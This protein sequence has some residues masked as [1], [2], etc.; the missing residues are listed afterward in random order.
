MARAAAIAGAG[1]AGDPPVDLR[2]RVGIE[3]EDAVAAAVAQRVGAGDDGLGLE[4]LGGPA[5]RHLGRHDALQVGLQAELV[6]GE[7]RAAVVAVQPQHA[8]VA[9]VAHAV[10]RLAADAGRGA[11]AHAHRGGEPG[12][13][14]AAARVDHAQLAGAVGGER[15]GAGVAQLQRAAAGGAGAGGAA[16]L[17][18]PRVAQ[19]DAHARTRDPADVRARVVVAEDPAE[20][21][22][23]ALGVAVGAVLGQPDAVAE[24]AAVDHVVRARG[25]RGDEHGGGR[26]AGEEQAS[27]VALELRR[28]ANVAVSAS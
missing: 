23:L 11:A 24:A 10:D 15:V 6:D 5:R 26:E 21:A 18:H 13:G 8:A 7:D 19:H 3:V 27:H 2:A 12:A 28:T 9:A 25:A 17:R 20:V 4:R 14:A 1:L 16:D 22:A